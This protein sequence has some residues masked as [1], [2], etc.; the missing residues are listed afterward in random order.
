MYKAIESLK[1]SPRMHYLSGAA[2]YV[3]KTSSKAD[4][5]ISQSEIDKVKASGQNW[6]VRFLLTERV[7]PSLE[8]YSNR[9]SQKWFKDP[10]R[11]FVRAIKYTGQLL[12]LIEQLHAMGIVHGNI[13][14]STVRQ[15]ISNSGKFL[16][17]DF[18]KSV[19][20]TEVDRKV[21]VDHMDDLEY[22]TAWELDRRMSSY[23]DDVMRA[24][25]VMAVLMNGKVY[26]DILDRFIHEDPKSF[27]ALKKSGNIFVVDGFD[28]V[29]KLKNIP[30]GSKDDINWK[31]NEIL[32]IV[33]SM[34]RI[35]A[36]PAYPKLFNALQGIL[37]IVASGEVF[38]GVL[39]ETKE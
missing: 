30:N 16:L 32:E 4:F 17:T 38:N 39:E 22:L 28:A 3:G 20:I 10:N 25:Q 31:L 34:T 11:N 1:I 13:K 7:G 33:Q 18:S 21:S 15:S 24:F 14:P 23:R 26:G 35:Y 27:Y 5:S 37:K 29:K 9:K 2:P 19:Y 8:D 36:K 12:Q 6:F